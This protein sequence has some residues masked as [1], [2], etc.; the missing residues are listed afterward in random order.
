MIDDLAEELARRL[1][2]VPIELRH[3][4]II[5]EEDHLLAC[6]R[7]K[8]RLPELVKIAFDGI[9]QVSRCRLTREVD[10]SGLQ[11]I[12]GVHQE[13]LRDDRLA[14]TSLTHNEGITAIHEE[15]LE[16]ELVF[17]SVIGRHE[18]LEE[19]LLRVE[20]ILV[21]DLITPAAELVSRRVQTLLIAVSSAIKVGLV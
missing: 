12:G 5:D 11:V 20:H 6:F 19:V 8:K 16:Q 15:F 9:D 2:A 7:L 21:R 3:V 18:D 1:R 14:D 4:H 17:D 10:E 13:V